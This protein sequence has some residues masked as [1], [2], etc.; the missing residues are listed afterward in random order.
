MLPNVLYSEKLGSD[1]RLRA[2]NIIKRQLRH[3]VDKLNYFGVWTHAS[4]KPCFQCANS[5]N[6][7]NTV[8]RCMKKAHRHMVIFI[9][10]IIII[11]PHLEVSDR[12]WGSWLKKGFPTTWMR[13]TPLCKTYRAQSRLGYRERHQILNIPLVSIRMDNADLIL[14]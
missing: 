14:I 5:S 11:M 12:A 9:I 10:I 4:L 7:A 3:V 1:Q 13:R 2:V 8:M 6:K